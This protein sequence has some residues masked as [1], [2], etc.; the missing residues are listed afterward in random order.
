M[1]DG[2]LAWSRGHQNQSLELC[3]GDIQRLL[4]LRYHTL[5]KFFP[6]DKGQQQNIMNLQNHIILSSYEIELISCLFII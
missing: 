6:S 1:E 4:E 5:D 2:R 3:V